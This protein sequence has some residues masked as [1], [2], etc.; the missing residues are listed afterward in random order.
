VS[1]E[2]VLARYRAAAKETSEAREFDRSARS[3]SPEPDNV[4]DLF[5]KADRPA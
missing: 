1:A 5:R 3:K 4:V 2:E